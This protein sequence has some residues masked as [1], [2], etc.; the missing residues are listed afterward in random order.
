MKNSNIKYDTDFIE[1]YFDGKLAGEELELFEKKLESDP[2]FASE[3]KLH[4]EINDFLRNKFDFIKK[5]EQ[6]EQIYEEVILKKKKSGDPKIKPIKIFNFKW[7]YKIAAAVVILIGVATILFL[8]FRPAKNDRLYSQYYKSYEASITVRGGV[9]HSE[10]LFEKAMGAYEK[11]DFKKSY[12]LFDELC[13]SD[14]EYTSAFFF[15][16]VSAMELE[17]YSDAI[18]SFNLVLGSTSLYIDEAEWYL[19][20]CYLKMSEFNKSKELLIKIAACDSYH[21]KDATRL[22]NDLPE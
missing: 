12:I 15:K 7:Y 16:G 11:N 14:K 19:A 9:Q 8:M 21:K 13:C 22:L 6:L 5:R 17:K 4:R 2:E 1:R 10:T 18:T 20:L 3:V